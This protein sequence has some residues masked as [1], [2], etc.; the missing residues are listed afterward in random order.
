MVT[1]T[2]IG[3]CALAYIAQLADDAVTND[4]AF[5]PFLA[6]SEPWRALT[7]AFLHSP[8]SPLHI[9]VNM[10]FLWQLGSYL[11]AL[12]GR[13]RYAALYLTSALGG[14]VAVVLLAQ[15][16]DRALTDPSEL[17]VYQSWFTGVVGASGAVF[18]LF[19]TVF[20][21]NRRLGRSS[22]PFYVTLLLNAVLGFVYP[23]ISWQ[24]HLGGLVTGGAIA[25]LLTTFGRRD[26]RR[27][28]WPAIAAV[29]V[30]L[31]A[32]LVLKLL[33]VPVG[34]R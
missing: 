12:L 18:G 28:Q 2:V 23:Q 25:A 19:A 7:A 15:P 21:V 4:F 31:V 8:S 13:A 34:Y 3:V 30:V 24:G 22:G 26:L 9:L 10:F 5:A 14:A 6:W 11:E 27:W 1:L 17:E 20:I 33:P 32:L 29:V 16:P